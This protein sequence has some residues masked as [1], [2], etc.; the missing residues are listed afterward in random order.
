MDMRP[1][2]AFVRVP[3]I[4]SPHPRTLGIFAPLE[5]PLF[6]CQQCSPRASARRQRLSGPKLTM[7]TRF[8][9]ESRL[10]T[11]SIIACARSS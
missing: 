3:R 1:G 10:S 4:R 7:P 9:I 6:L 2:A 8:P 11:R 5:E